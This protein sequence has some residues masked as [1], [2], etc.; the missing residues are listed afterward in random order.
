MQTAEY[1]RNYA[2]EEHY[3][4]FVGRRKLI[5]QTLLPLVQRLGA[6]RLLDIGC[7]T[8]YTLSAL[9]EHT[10]AFGLDIA[11][12]A[13][14]FSKDRGLDRLVQ[15]TALDLP[16]LDDSLDAITALDVLEHL[17][18]DEAALREWH[19]ACRPG[20]YLVL[21]VP[22][23]RSLWSGEDHVSQHRRRYTRAELAEKVAD[24]G[25]AVRRITYANTLLLP[26]VFGT[27]LYYR[28]LDR[29]ALYRSN[30][31]PLPAW[32]NRLLTAVFSFEASC[33]TR[34]DSPIGSSLMC[35]AQKPA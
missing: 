22:A 2:F 1:A 6:A 16:F 32:L 28:L 15:A 4:W 12:E 18:D 17:D 11:G 29:Q 34:I 23:I 21:N 9:G 27:I 5:L 33:L 7:G 8:G 26:A 35:L 20:G 31:R 25:F 19:R 10:Q 24:A 14:G 13:L 3:W 30:L